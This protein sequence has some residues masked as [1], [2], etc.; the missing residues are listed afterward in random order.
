MVVTMSSPFDHI[1]NHL[2]NFIEKSIQLLPDSNRMHTH[3]LRLTRSLQ[4]LL[5]QQIET[6]GAI[7]AAITI[8]FNPINLSTWRS[9]PEV[10]E[11]LSAAIH[12][13]ASDQGIPA[14]LAPAIHLEVDPALPLDSFTIRQGAVSGRAGETK[15]LSPTHKPARHIKSEQA[16]LYLI[17]QENH[18]FPLLEAAINIGRGPHNNL[19]INDPRVSRLHA[20]IRTVD[21]VYTIFDLNSRGGVFVNG[22]PVTQAALKSGD[23]ISLAGC[24]LRCLDNPPHNS[25]LLSQNNPHPQP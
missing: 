21:G 19:V 11:Y 13:L 7:P 9:H 18:P 15:A 1:E 3:L 14:P 10:L 5:Q 2:N 23:T 16:E 20:Q 24:K 17:H 25:A 8:F 4:N 12:D 22:Q 6:Q